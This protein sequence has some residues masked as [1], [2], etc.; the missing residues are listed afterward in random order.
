MPRKET[1]SA[2]I[3]GRRMRNGR[4]RQIADSGPCL[5]DGIDREATDNGNNIGSEEDF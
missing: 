5:L 2:E 3:R 1:K 4:M